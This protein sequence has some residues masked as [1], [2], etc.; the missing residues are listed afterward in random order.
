MYV[1]IT[2]VHCSRRPEG[3][4]RS[5]EIEVADVSCHVGSKNWI[6]SA[7]DYWATSPTPRGLLKCLIFSWFVKRMVLRSCSM[8]VCV[9]QR[10]SVMSWF[11]STMYVPGIELKSLGLVTSIYLLRHLTG[12][13][14]C[15]MYPLYL[16]MQNHKLKN[17][18]MCKF[19]VLSLYSVHLNKIEPYNSY[20]ASSWEVEPGRTAV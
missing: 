8:C 9:N 4:I 7:L 14:G 20:D 6:D 5:P 3:G 15:F 18:Y 16:W 19:T 12:P 17:E 13:K 1:C 11:S 10:T 2:C